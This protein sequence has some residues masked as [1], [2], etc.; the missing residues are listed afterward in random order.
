M[1]LSAQPGGLA[2]TKLDDAR[3]G[4]YSRLARFWAWA[5][6]DCGIALA[7]GLALL[8]VYAVTAQVQINGSRSPYATDVGE[9]QNALPRW[10]TLH[11]TGYPQYTLLGSLFVS[12]LGVLGIPPA[13]AASLF[14]A[15]WGAVAVALTYLFVRALGAGRIASVG[16]AIASGLALSLW[17]DAALAE[18]HTMTMSLTVAALLA[19]L[20]YRQSGER[21]QLLWLAALLAQ[22][23][24]HQ[25]AVAFIAPAV[26]VLV[27]GRWR[28][29]W[30]N[31]LPIMAHGLGALATY[32]YLPLRAWMGATWT[33]N[34]P[35][36]WQG[37]WGLVLD[38]KSE[39]IV[40]LPG[41]LAELWSRFANAVGL[42]R[43]DLPL[44]LLV[45]GL[46]GL[47]LLAYRGR[48]REAASLLLV[49]LT[50]LAV[51]MI[52]WE[53]RISD[54]LLAVKLPAV[55]ACAVGLAF[56]VPPAPR[57]WVSATTMA[58]M[59][60]LALFLGY[61][62]APQ[63]LAVTRDRSSEA[64]V[65]RVATLANPSHPTTVWMPWG[66]DYWALRYAQTYR[67]ELPGLAIADH[68]ASLEDIVAAGAMLVTPQETF[69]VFAPSWFEERLGG[70]A[71]SSAAYGLV[72]ITAAPESGA[73]TADM[74]ALGNGIAV[75]STAV[76]WQ[77]DD[78]LL[79]AV[80]WLSTATP[81]QDYAVGVHLL[82]AS[83][84]VIAQADSQH[85]VYGWY[86]TSQWVIDE[87]VRDHYLLAI[88]AGASP[89][90]IRLFMYT[91]DEAGFH[92]TAAVTLPVP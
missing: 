30:Q 20:R 92:N 53:G 73:P 80:S 21:R 88:P 90:A 78:A 72:T 39:R 7:L 57:R 41:S 83:S 42:L 28:A 52:I 10:G 89:H 66:H 54:A 27:W 63:V 36:T 87:L 65:Q 29:L 50:Y 56:C 24:V 48:K 5:G 76:T 47:G 86:P 32:L 55:W 6:S 9:I 25:R 38:T 61:P 67:D 62:H 43:Q 17:M 82:D 84:A 60:A 35:G 74:V 40:R 3:R 31:L 1:P 4:S 91:Q 75:A 33:F 85:P 19:A 22:G 18:V 37:F 68:N 70:L 46:L 8:I 59:L 64:V 49:A 77:G 81:D 16:A 13:W 58:V 34:A 51:T 12:L 69:Y 23:V 45:L 11:F 2:A 26:L 71:L 79:L 44:T 15:V 14:S